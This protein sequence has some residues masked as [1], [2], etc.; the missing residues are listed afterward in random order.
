MFK[1]ALKN[2][3][4]IVLS[5]NVVINLKLDFN[6]GTLGFD[7]PDDDL[8]TILNI[9]YGDI[10]KDFIVDFSKDLDDEQLDPQ[11]EPE[12]Q[13][14]PNPQPEPEKDESSKYPDDLDELAKMLN[15]DI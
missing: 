11:P 15:F 2:I 9:D 13:P 14:E 6:D 12:Q 3:K 5:N 1:F 7:F 10:E 8:D 4:R